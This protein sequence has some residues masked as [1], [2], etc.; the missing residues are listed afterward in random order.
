MIRGELGSYPLSIDLI[1]ITVLTS[2]NILNNDTDNEILISARTTSEKLYQ[3]GKTSW[4]LNMSNLMYTI[5]KNINMN[6]FKPD[7]FFINNFKVTLKSQFMNYWKSVLNKAST[8]TDKISTYKQIK[9]NFHE[10]DYIRL[11]KNKKH[12][13]AFATLN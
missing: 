3:E 6:S 5:R 9:H 13:R 2:G 11:I 4:Y 8:S 7:R 10:E 1:V 12:R